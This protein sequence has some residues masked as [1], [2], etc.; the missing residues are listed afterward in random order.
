MQVIEIHDNKRGTVKITV[1]WNGL[2]VDQSYKD[3]I[4]TSGTFKEGSESYNKLVAMLK[5]IFLDY[6]AGKLK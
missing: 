2:V 5:P 3:G 6:M 1:V 4:P